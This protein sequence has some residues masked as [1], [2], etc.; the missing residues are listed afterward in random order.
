MTEYNPDLLET[1]LVDIIANKKTT[2]SFMAT[3][4]KEN[5]L[6]TV[7]F[8]EDVVERERTLNIF[9]AGGHMQYFLSHAI[10]K[11]S[12]STYVVAFDG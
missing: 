6:M 12:S 9:D 4:S 8:L 7:N 2:E 11:A 3:K 10:L 1:K 5:G